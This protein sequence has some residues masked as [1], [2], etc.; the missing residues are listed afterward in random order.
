METISRLPQP[1]DHLDGDGHD[2]AQ[3]YLV[4][5]TTTL[6]AL[7]RGHPSVNIN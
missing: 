1:A 7:A 2:A 6:R 3:L 5:L 4:A